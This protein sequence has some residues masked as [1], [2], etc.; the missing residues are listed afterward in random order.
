M[1]HV[2]VCVGCIVNA[3]TWALKSAG[4]QPT[5]VVQVSLLQYFHPWNVD[6]KAAKRAASMDEKQEEL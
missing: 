2:C 3:N 1:C 4:S 6:S 5:G